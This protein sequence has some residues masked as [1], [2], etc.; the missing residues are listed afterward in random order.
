M[1]LADAPGRRPVHG[2]HGLAEH[3]PDGAGHRRRHLPRDAQGGASIVGPSFSRIYDA[4]I[5]PW[6]KF[7]HVIEPRV[8]YNYVSDVT[9][10]A[11]IPAFDEV[12]TVLGQNQMRY[13]IVNRLLARPAAAN[14]RSAE[15]IASFEMAQT[16]AFS[17]PQTVFGSNILAST[18]EPTR[19]G[20][21]DPAPV[22]RRE[23]PP[24][25]ATL[26]RRT[27]PAG[28]AGTTLTAGA[29]WGTDYFNVS[30]FAQPADRA[31]GD[32]RITPTD[33]VR[34]AGGV[35]LGPLFRVDTKSRG[36]CGRACVQEDRSLLT[37]KGSCFTVFLE[38]RQLRLPP[39]PRNDYRL[40]VNLK[41]I[42][43]LL[44]VNG[45]LDA[46]FGR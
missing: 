26:V 36:T 12:D 19:S 39:A 8:D 13:A 18:F 6:D 42:G 40:V 20:R 5:G 33:Q 17:Q 43:T 3:E 31:A 25:R 15:E 11:R 9:D 23:L 22:E 14:G 24:R 10:P 37:Y 32:A 44:D 2:L 4:A 45:S 27:R 46:L 34:V 35:D 30:W 28:H 38:V 16:Y 21:G 41:D 7:K 29:N 1:A